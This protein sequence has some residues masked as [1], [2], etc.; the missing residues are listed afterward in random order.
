[1]NC[2]DRGTKQ[3]VEKIADAILFLDS[4]PCIKGEMLSVVGGQRAS[5]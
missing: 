4:A 1:V 5:H 3:C 2:R